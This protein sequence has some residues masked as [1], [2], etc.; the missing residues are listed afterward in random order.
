MGFPDSCGD[1]LAE[2]VHNGA[3]PKL[4]VPGDF[5]VVRGGSTPIPPS[6]TTFS[7]A[8]GPTLEA[9]AAA[10][11]YGQIRVSTVD[12]IRQNGGVVEWVPELSR[13]GTVNRQHVNVTEAGTTTF[14]EV[15][16]NP[17]PRVQR[18]H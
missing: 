10:V 9:A 1:Q 11:P 13:G 15:R 14:S 8:V 12:E 2:A 18:I 17:V 16:P 7:A 3:D 4:V 5:V 6:A